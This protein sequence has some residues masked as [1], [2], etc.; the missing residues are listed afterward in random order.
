LIDQRFHRELDGH[1]VGQ[2]VG[3]ISRKANVVV[4]KT[5]GKFGS[6]HDLRRSFG[7]RWAKRVMPAVLRRLMRHAS[8]QTTMAYYVDLD[9]ADVADQ[10]WA[11]WGAIGANTPAA[12]NTVGNTRPDAAKKPEEATAGESAEASDNQHVAVSLS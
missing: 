8:I 4:N 3:K 7:T 2:I 5:D 9:A 12:G 11:G 6:A 10:L 1:R